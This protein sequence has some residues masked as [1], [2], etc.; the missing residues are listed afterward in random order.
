MDWN[1][2]DF[3]LILAVDTNLFVIKRILSKRHANIGDLVIFRDSFEDQNKMLEDVN[4]LKDY[5][6]EGGTN[7][8]NAPKIKLC[9]QI[10]FLESNVSDPLLLS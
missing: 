3:K 6:I 4:T 10:N 1:F 9:Y 5:G 8:E 2:M 7:K